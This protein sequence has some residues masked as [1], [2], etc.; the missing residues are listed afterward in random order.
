MMSEKEKQE[1]SFRVHALMKALSKVV[2]QTLVEMGEDKEAR[3]IILAGVEGAVSCIANVDDAEAK[4]VMAYYLG[5]PP[6]EAW[7]ETPTEKPS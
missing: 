5:F 3:F 4:S 6:H 7:E 2:H 1:I